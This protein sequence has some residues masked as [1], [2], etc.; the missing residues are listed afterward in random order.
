MDGIVAN[1]RVQAEN[2]P[3]SSQVLREAAWEGEGEIWKNWRRGW[4]SELPRGELL[5]KIGTVI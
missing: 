4:N 2:A 3:A 1:V 5:S